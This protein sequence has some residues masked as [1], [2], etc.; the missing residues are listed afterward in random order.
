MSRISRLT[1]LAAVFS[2][3]TILSLVDSESALAAVGMLQFLRF[4]KLILRA[5]EASKLVWKT[6]SAKLSRRILLFMLTLKS[7]LSDRH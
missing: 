4:K 1:F 5:S 3:Q 7:F 2:V 6:V